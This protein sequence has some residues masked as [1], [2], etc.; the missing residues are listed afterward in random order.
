MAVGFRREGGALEAG[1]IAAALTSPPPPHGN[2]VHGSQERRA[3]RRSPRGPGWSGFQERNSETM[4]RWASRKG[5]FYVCRNTSVGAES[6]VNSTSPSHVCRSHHPQVVTSSSPLPMSL[7]D[8]SL[9]VAGRL[10]C[11]TGAPMRDFSAP[12]FALNR[13]VM[14]DFVCPL[15]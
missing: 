4:G 11:S 12:G 8:P 10:H 7:R 14:V 2:R 15:G 3:L 9:H 13:E 1:G 5:A 6:R